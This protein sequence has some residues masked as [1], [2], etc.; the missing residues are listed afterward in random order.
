MR[1]PLTLLLLLLTIRSF[2]QG[3]S[4]AGVC[5]AGPIG[6]VIE[7][8]SATDAL[9]HVARFTFS[10]AIGEQS[11]V[12]T[13]VVPE[14][15]LGITDRWGVQL[16]VPYM[17]ASGNLGSNNGVGDPTITTSYAF[18]KET[19]RRLDGT[20]G[21]KLN[22]GNA[23]T[24]SSSLDVLPMPYQTSL[25]TTDLLAGVNFRF[26]RWQAAVAYQHVLVNE[27]ENTF[28][29][30]GW[31]DDTDALG[32][33]ESDGLLRASD[34]VARV[35]Y[36]FNFG[37]L[38]LQP[39]LLGIYH[40]SKDQVHPFTFAEERVE[41]EGSDGLTLNLTADARYKFSDTWSLEASYGSPVI[42]RDVRPDGLTRAMVLNVG[43][44]FAF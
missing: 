17:A 28:T 38:S 21:V 16:K 27:N 18:I 13:Q 31:M 11:T 6:E 20:V 9:R 39:G 1:H 37:D 25:G 26:G 34:A 23:N 41:V 36:G 5:T 2:S 42:T 12:I 8:S 30:A 7:D 14:L 40:V 29:H 33:F 22:S 44:R 24:P 35:Q 43:L 3:C 32:Y 4:D 15:S 19:H 10:Y